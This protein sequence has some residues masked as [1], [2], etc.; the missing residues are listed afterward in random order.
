MSNSDR[1]P[2]LTATVLDQDFLDACQDNLETQLELTVDIETPS[3]FIRASDRPKYVG[4]VYYDNRLKFP[5]IGRTVG[6]WLSTEIELS[7]LKLTLNNADGE[8]DEFLPGN[9]GYGGFIGKSVEVKLGLRDVSSTYTTIFKGTVS[10]VSGFGRDIKSIKLIARDDYE[11]LQKEIPGTILS[12]ANFADI[13]PDIAGT[14]CPIIY[15]SWN[16]EGNPATNNASVPAFVVNGQ[17][18]R[19]DPVNDVELYVSLNDLQSL[20][21]SNVWLLRGSTY[22]N[23]NSADVNTTTFANVRQFYI[24]QDTGNTL[25]DGSNF[26][27]E[28]SDTFFVSV[29][30]KDLGAYDDNIVAQAKDILLTYGGV[31]AGELDANWDTFRDKSTP[32]QDAISTVKSRIYL[33]ETQTV[34]QYVLSLLEQ[35]RLEMFIDRNLKIKLNSLHF[36]DYEASPSFRISNFDVERNTLEPKLD[37]RIHFNRGQGF[38]NFL[39]DITKEAY[40][41]KLYENQAAI[42]QQGGLEIANKV[43]FPNL[44]IESDAVNNLTEILKLASAGFE[45]VYLTVTWRSLLLDIGDFVSLDVKIGSTLYDAVPCMIREIGYDPDGIKIPLRLWSFQLAPFTG[46][47]GAPNSVGGESA[48]ITEVVQTP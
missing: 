22:Y 42:T 19:F 18:A 6:E 47:T 3:G 27:L 45:N 1:R 43:T 40:K 48:T 24:L 12:A 5:I 8:Y 21:T 28:E 11:K 38:F 46:Y 36:S 35:V 23:I 25:I 9:A 31:T 4:D 34:L 14:A 15:G 17:L 2:Y 26:V 10:S 44:Y 29:V 13:D 32:A 20:D 37:D 16:T 33:Q 39:P 7:T 30:G 41:T